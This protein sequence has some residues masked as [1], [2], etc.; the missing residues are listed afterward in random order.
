MKFWSRH[1]TELLL[2]LLGCAM[3]LTIINY[4]PDR[5]ELYSCNVK[6][7]EIILTKGELNRVGILVFGRLR[8]GREVALNRYSMEGCFRWTPQTTK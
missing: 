3:S 2:F 7:V 1:R 5:N 8:D 4:L 6:G